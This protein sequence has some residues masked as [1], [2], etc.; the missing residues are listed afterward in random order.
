M[1]LCVSNNTHYFTHN[2]KVCNVVSEVDTFRYESSRRQSYMQRLYFEYLDVQNKGGLVFFYTLTYNDKALPHYRGRSCFSYKDIRY[3]T[4]GALSK[5]LLRN[6]RCSLRYLCACERGEGKGKRGFDK[7]GLGNNPHYHFIFFLHPLEGFIAPTP[8]VFRDKVAQIW[9]GSDSFVN[10]KYAKFGHS[11]PG[12]NL[13]L[14]V[15]SDAFSYVCKYVCKDVAERDFE[16][17]LRKQYYSEGMNLGIT[18]NVIF[19]LYHFLRDNELYNIKN[20]YDFFDAFYLREFSA[21]RKRQFGNFG[22]LDFYKSVLS[23]TGKKYLVNYTKVIEDFWKDYYL[24]KYVDVC[25]SEYKREYSGKVRCSKSL[26]I[27]GLQFVTETSNGVQV[28]INSPKGYKVQPACLYYIRHK[29]YTTFKC[30][31]TGNVLYRLND[32]GIN[33]KVSR[34]K[35]NCDSLICKIREFESCRFAICPETWTGALNELF[36]YHDINEVLRRY[37]LYKL[38]YQYRY[39]VT[40]DKVALTD[41][42]CLDNVAADYRTFLQDSA[43]VIDYDYNTIDSYF[44]S[45]LSTDDL[46]SFEHHPAFMDYIKYFKLLDDFLDAASSYFDRNRQKNFADKSDFQKKHS[47]LRF[48]Q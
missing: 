27:Y 41:D 30:S 3:V 18:N 14:V 32:S 37:S 12:D 45:F 36:Y 34:L 8:Q 38:V 16:D 24:P 31:V 28:K 25:L 29:Y 17:N 35:S 19:S 4:N 42:C 39:Y 1:N 47:A 22:L 7:L 46:F 5:W 43:Y 10:W 21:W 26:G 40:F 13:G 48:N 15:S 23:R 2:T 11:Q 33:F 9:Q 44:D 6:Y 20:K